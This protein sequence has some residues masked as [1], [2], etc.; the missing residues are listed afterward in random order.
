LRIRVL[1]ILTS[2]YLGDEKKG[3]REEEGGEV[4]SGLLGALRN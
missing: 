3:I 1:S 2:E 4:L